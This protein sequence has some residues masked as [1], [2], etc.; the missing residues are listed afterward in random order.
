[1]SEVRANTFADAA[2]TGPADLTG[3]AAP[4]ALCLLDASGPTAVIES[5]NVS[6]ITDDGTGQTTHSFTTNMAKVQAGAIGGAPNQSANHNLLVNQLATSSM[7]TF[8]RQSNNLTNV[9]GDCSV[10]LHGDL[11]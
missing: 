10:A 8:V 1:M 9:D 6:S 3:Q 11:A 4:R 2:G 5:L 7:L